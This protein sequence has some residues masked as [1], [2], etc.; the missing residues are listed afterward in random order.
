MF[1]IGYF[2]PRIV[3]WVIQT[4]ESLHSILSLFPIFSEPVSQKKKK[5][6]QNYEGSCFPY[7]FTVYCLRICVYLKKEAILDSLM[8]II[9]C[10]LINFVLFQATKLSSWIA[11]MR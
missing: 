5:G 3:D 6:F 7:N 2:T 4:L 8:A 11:Y 10:E 1:R 9:K